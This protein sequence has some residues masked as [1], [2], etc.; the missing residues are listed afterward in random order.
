MEFW[1]NFV[2]HLV[3]LLWHFP[4]CVRH[5]SHRSCV[6]FFNFANVGFVAFARVC[7]FVATSIRVVSFLPGSCA[8][9]V[10]VVHVCC[11]RLCSIMCLLVACICC[12]PWS[13]AMPYRFRSPPSQSSYF[14]PSLA[15]ISESLIFTLRLLLAIQVAYGISCSKFMRCPAASFVVSLRPSL[16][17]HASAT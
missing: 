14:F 2:L 6:C 3:Y 9:F 4:S 12:I 8:C 1:V 11:V 10:G 7:V 5:W 16:S 13:P 17:R 15:A